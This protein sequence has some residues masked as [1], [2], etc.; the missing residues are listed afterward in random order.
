MLISHTYKTKA[1]NVEKPT[2]GIYKT[3]DGGHTWTEIWSGL[4]VFRVAVDPK[5]PT[6][7]YAAGWAG[8][9]PTHRDSFLL[10]RSNDSGR[11]WA[12]AR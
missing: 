2:G 5:N 11:T 7:I 3:T 4:G 8:R 12:I 9:D 1:G 10:L 6:T